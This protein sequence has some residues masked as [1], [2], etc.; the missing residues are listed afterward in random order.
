MNNMV[1]DPQNDDYFENVQDQDQQRNEQ[2]NDRGQ[3]EEANVNEN[4]GAY[5]APQVDPHANK[6]GLPQ[7]SKKP[8]EKIFEIDKAFNQNRS[9]SKT[10]KSKPASKA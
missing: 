10:A 3:E 8:P 5:N 6:D 9:P 2:N 7:D 1:M 4:Q